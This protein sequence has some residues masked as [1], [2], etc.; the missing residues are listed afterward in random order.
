MSQQEREK[1]TADDLR[2]AYIRGAQAALEWL[3]EIYDDIQ[4]TD[5]WAHYMTCEKCGDE[6][7]GDCEQEGES[8]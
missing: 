2:Q 4:E 3:S 7:E 8:E 5:A 6:H 1:V